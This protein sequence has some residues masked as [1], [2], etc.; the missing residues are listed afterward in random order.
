MK[1]VILNG[2]INMLHNLVLLSNHCLPLVM[3][4]NASFMR[5]SGVVLCSLDGIRHSG[6][7]AEA[8][9][10]PVGVTHP[11]SHWLYL[12]RLWE[13]WIDVVTM[14][15]S[16]RNLLASGTSSVLLPNAQICQQGSVR[17]PVGGGLTSV[18][19]YME[20]AILNGAISMLH[21]LVL[22]ANHCLPLVMVSNACCMRRSGV[23]LCSVDGIRR[24]G[25]YGK[26]ALF[27]FGVTHP[28]AHWLYLW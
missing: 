19:S 11:L 12:W 15:L 1:T 18:S 26:A 8:A 14:K 22:L 25:R 5:R 28:L 6:R 4:S 7:H 27:P 2:A 3:V 13:C 16:G 10:L 9:L 17:G 23:V 20:T 24:S 21:N